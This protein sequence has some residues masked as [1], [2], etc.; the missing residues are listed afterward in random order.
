MPDFT[1]TVDTDDAAIIQKVAAQ[2]GRTPREL[3]ELHI[4][5][6]SKGQIDGFFRDKIRGM[7]T[8]QLIVLL[9]EIE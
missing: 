7:T 4:T 2:T 1:I 8:A 9:G 3:I 5:N 6:W